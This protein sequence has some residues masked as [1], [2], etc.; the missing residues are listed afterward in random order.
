MSIVFA[1]L[2]PHPPLLIPEIGR[3]DRDRVSL[4]DQGLTKLAGLIHNSQP[5]LLIMISPHGSVFSDAIAILHK[6]VLQGDLGQFGAPQISFAEKIDLEFASELEKSAEELGIMVALLDEKKIKEYRID[7]N[8][9]HGIM[10]PLHYIRKIRPNTPL[11]AITIGMLPYEDLYF[12]GTLIKQLSAKLEKKVAV[13]A[14]GDLSHRLTPHAPAG[15]NPHGREF[16][17]FLVKALKKYQVEKLFSVDN[18]LIEKAGECGFRPLI[19]MLGT[20]DGLKVKS[21]VISY[22]GPFGVGYCVAAFKPTGEEIPSRVDQLYQNR[23]DRIRGIHEREHLFVRLARQTISN[24]ICREKL[25]SSEELT[26]ELT[27]PAGVFVSI[28][29]H[30]QLR[31]CIGTIVPTQRNLA[32]EIKQNAISAATRDPRF[33]P[34]EEEE[35]ADLIISVDVLSEPEPIQSNTELDPLKYGVIVRQGEKSGLLLPDLEGI[36]TVA[37]QIEIAKQKA[38][39]TSNQGMRLFRFEVRRYE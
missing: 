36:D 6:P 14:S 2:A 31:G 26:S 22:E 29:K 16:D 33:F 19:L 27:E 28:K 3:T 34:I 23:L 12:F 13:I 8:L 11:L 10:V 1:G 35:L 21:E 17:Q 37:E 9:D 38:G 39:I 5:D 15:Y 32:E 25:V 4:T 20:L 18:N 7:G 30:G 24:Y